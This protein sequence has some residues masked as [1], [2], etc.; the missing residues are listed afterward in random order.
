MKMVSG[1]TS[2]ELIKPSSP[3][4]AHQRN[5]Q[6]SFLDQL[7]PPTYIH[8]ILYFK[9]PAAS[10]PELKR[11][12]SDALSIY[13]PLAGRLR[14][15][16]RVECNDDGAEY[17]ESRFNDVRISEV[18]ENP[19]PE[20]LAR[21]VPLSP[22]GDG[23][24]DIPLA[25]QASFFGCG[26][27]ALGI[28]MSHRVADA[29]SM[30]VFVNSWAACCRGDGGNQ[31]VFDIS[32]RFSPSDFSD[33][34]KSVQL[35]PPP[36]PPPSA[37]KVVT[38]IFSFDGKKLAAVKKASSGPLMTNPTRVEAVSAFIWKHLI[39]S[40]SARNPNPVFA[41]TH[42]VDIRER[43][44]PPLPRHFFGNACARAMAMTS[45]S[46]AQDYYSLALELR[47]VI[48]KADADYVR[49]LEDGGE[50][51]KYYAVSEENDPELREGG[52]TVEV[53]GFTSWCRLPAYEAD[54]GWGKPCWVSII[55]VPV[56]NLVFFLRTECGDG[57]E[58]WV[59]MVEED[60]AMIERN[61]HL[62]DQGE[63]ISELINV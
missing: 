34:F 4:P 31:P 29:M 18:V 36:P 42:A 12:L 48:R 23:D 41:A 63:N 3:T 13:Y 59:S 58:A 43:A 22:S 6:L 26:G 20:E 9:A 46:P 2:K 19:R 51:L 38:K 55:G 60:I 40:A 61:Y 25:V 15:N 62:L 7:A 30:V 53:C 39:E 56:K 1:E 8:I 45:S 32:S 50:F 54:F 47:R 27:A 17:I 10:S 37:E 44:S 11:S 16:S 5:L 52:K 57:I 24:G 28:C 14:E 35:V 33:F 49:R 21:F